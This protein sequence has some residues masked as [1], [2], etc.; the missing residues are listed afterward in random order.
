MEEYSVAAQVW[1]LSPCDMCELA[2]NS[3][4]QSGFSH[5][6]KCQFLSDRYLIPGPAG[7]EISKTNVASIRVAYRFE[8]L[9]DELTLVC[10]HT[11]SQ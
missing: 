9:V 11:L 8:T 4:K 2:A 10:G 6:M 5:E 7:N 1:K 3:V